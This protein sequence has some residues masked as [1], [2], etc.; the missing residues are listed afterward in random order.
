MHDSTHDQ[1]EPEQVAEPRWRPED[2]EYCRRLLAQ[3][4]RLIAGPAAE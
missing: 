3:A 2:D 4:R 1:P